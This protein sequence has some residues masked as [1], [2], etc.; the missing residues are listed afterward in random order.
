MGKKLNIEASSPLRKSWTSPTIGSTVVETPKS[1]ELAPI[2]VILPPAN[3]T[4]TFVNTK[5]PISRKSNTA[6]IGLKDGYIRATV[7]TK[8]DVIEKI[9]AYAYWERLKINQAYALIFDEFLK[10]KDIKPIP[11]NKKGE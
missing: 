3:N 1:V 5:K 9:K 6:T 2:P 8:I 10:D 11:A 7:I 4:P